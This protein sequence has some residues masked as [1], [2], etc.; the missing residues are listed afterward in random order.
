MSI[1]A[2]VSE[3]ESLKTEIKTIL[4]RLR[5]LRKREKEVEHRISEFLKAN[6]HPGV[7]HQNI[8]I[9]LEEKEKPGPKR[10]KEKD[11]DAM[12]VLE[13]YG[14]RDTQKVWEEIMSAR[15]GDPVLKQ[16]LKI[17]KVS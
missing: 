3:L 13:K 2:D 7:K 17:K 16:S 15:K 4:V 11:A 10:L 12:N 5:M 1:K 9:I 8:A 14:I 6:D